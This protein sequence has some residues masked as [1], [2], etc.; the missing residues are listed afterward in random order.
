MLPV[1]RH[2]SQKLR[3]M[4][5]ETGVLGVAPARWPRGYSGIQGWRVSNHQRRKVLEFG[6]NPKQAWPLGEC[7]QC[8]PPCPPPRPPWEPHGS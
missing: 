8:G 4:F 7:P 6:H 1:G 3:D 2:R 5:E